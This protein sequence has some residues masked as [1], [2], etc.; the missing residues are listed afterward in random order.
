MPNNF[1]IMRTEKV[2]SVASLA[3][4]EK[5]CSRE[6]IPKNADR[7]R[8]QLNRSIYKDQ[9]TL[10]QRFAKMTEGQKIRKNAVMAI[11]VLM[12]ASP[13][14]MKNMDTLDAWIKENR[15]WLCKEFG[16]SNVVRM[17]LHMDE[18]TPHLH[19]VVIPIDEKG[20]LN[21]RSFL[22][23]ADKLSRL[24]DTYAKAM[25]PFNLERGIKGSKAHHKTVKEFYRA[26]EGA[27]RKSLPEP[28]QE[29]KKGIMGQKTVTEDAVNYYTRANKAFK[30]QGMQIVDLQ[31]QL[32]K[33]KAHN[34]T[35]SVAERMDQAQQKRELQALKLQA[36][37]FPTYKAK[38]RAWDDL[39]EG[40]NN[41]QDKEQAEKIR[42][43]INDILTSQRAIQQE[44]DNTYEQSSLER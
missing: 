36:E 38:S 2:K 33:E 1:A 15:E 20:K 8:T 21:C 22:G 3:N 18:T 6:K 4:L 40:L 41:W 42:E 7:E 24:Q 17:Y 16:K 13:D 32:R 12:T 26:I 14:A 23:G 11:E 28:K 30:Q 35:V 27:E 19:A 10:P 43:Q 39:K 44:I 34:K 9:L 5:H 37:Q 29:V 25:Q 31:E